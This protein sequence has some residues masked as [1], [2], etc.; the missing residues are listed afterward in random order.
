[1][2]S[3]DICEFSSTV[4][5]IPSSFDNNAT[6]GETPSVQNGVD[7]SSELKSKQ[8]QELASFVWQHGLLVEDDGCQYWAC[9]LCIN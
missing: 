3:D 9:N 1:M 2:D 4:S 7:V 5:S 6:V 8:E